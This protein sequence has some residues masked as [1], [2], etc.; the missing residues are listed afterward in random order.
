M[1][2]TGQA[3]HSVG[4]DEAHEM[5]VNRD[6]KSAVVHPNKE[7]INRL[8][9][10]FPYRS[11]VIQNFKKQ[12]NPHTRNDHNKSQAQKGR[13]NIQAMLEALTKSD[14]LPAQATDGVVLRNGFTG[15]NASTAQQLDLINFR[16]IGQTDFD[17]Y[18]EHV[19]LHTGNI[20]APVKRHQLKTFCT[21]SKN[22]TKHQFAKLQS[23]KKHIAQCLKKRLL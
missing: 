11:K 9:L 6:C 22:V 16:N 2:I 1:S 10:Y 18:V 7:F 15:T 5:L 8:A 3:W 13:E 20:K 12:L 19:Y 17:A 4:L 23:E 14:T 21:T